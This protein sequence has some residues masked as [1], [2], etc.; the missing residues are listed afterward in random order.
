MGVG[1]LPPEPRRGASAREGA[2]LI[3]KWL[4]TKGSLGRS[5]IEGCGDDAAA[6][7]GIYDYEQRGRVWSGF[8]DFSDYYYYNG[9][10]I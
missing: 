3:A 4:C 10:G 1:V 9:G 7:C 6:T 2:S 5:I 8:S